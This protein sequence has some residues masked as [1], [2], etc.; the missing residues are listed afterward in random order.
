LA[1]QKGP[2]QAMKEA[3]LPAETAHIA[4]PLAM[5]RLTTAEHAQPH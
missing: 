2:F 5:S 1:L 3:V 4:N